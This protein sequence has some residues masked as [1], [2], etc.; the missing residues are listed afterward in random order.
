MLFLLLSLWPSVTT[1][2]LRV[3][4]E[5]LPCLSMC[6][7]TGTVWLTDV[8]QLRNVVRN[9]LSP[10]GL[11]M[12]WAVSAAAEQRASAWD[13]KEKVCEITENEPSQVASSSSKNV[14]WPVCATKWLRLVL[15]ID[16]VLLLLP[17]RFYSPLARVHVCTCVCT[18]GS[19]R[20]FC[21]SDHKSSPRLR[22][23]LQQKIYLKI[24][25]TAKTPLV[26]FFL[27]LSHVF[28]RVQPHL[29]SIT[30]MHSHYIA[31]KQHQDE[32]NLLLKEGCSVSR[33]ASFCITD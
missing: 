4:L 19:H 15:A 28:V 22:D 3:S 14:D 1:R 7:P 20:T 5:T 23:E 25:K 16:W 13:Q 27:L 32:L 9:C 31:V 24:N 21:M 17:L 10:E 33:S 2:G 30:P 6:W 29:T 18:C 26:F 12:L 11:R 8:P